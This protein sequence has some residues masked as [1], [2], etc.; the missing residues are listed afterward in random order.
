MIPVLLVD[1]DRGLCE[2]LRDG[3]ARR[4]YEAAVVHDPEKVLERV[5]HEDFDAIVCDVN[6]PGMNGIE[7]CRRIVA[8]RADVPVI[9]LTAFGS[10]DTAVAAIRA[11]A[12]DFISKPV[13]IDALALALQRAV[14][15]RRLAT[16]VRRLRQEMDRQALPDDVIGRSAAMRAVHDLI[17]R[18]AQTDASVLITGES[19]TGKEV[20]AR[21]IHAASPRAARPFVAI[22]CA[23]LPEALLESELF[24]HVRGAFTDA[25]ESRTGLLREADG[26]TVFLDEIGDMPLGLQPKL[27]RVLQER[28]VR[29]IGGGKEV[30]IDVRFVSAT[31]RD[32]RRPWRRARNLCFRINVVGTSRSRPCAPAAR[33]TSSRSCSASLGEFSAQLKKPCAASRRRRPKP[34]RVSLAGERPRA[35]EQHREGGDARPVRHDRDRRP[36][37]RRG[38]RAGRR[39]AGVA[40]ARRARLAQREMGRH[41]IPCSRASRATRPPPRITRIERKTLYRKLEQW[42][43]RSGDDELPRST[44]RSGARASEPELRLQRG[45]GVRGALRRRRRAARRVGPRV[46]G[47]SFRVIAPRV[48]REAAVDPLVE[49]TGA[50]GVGV[51]HVAAHRDLELP[52]DHEEAGLHL[53]AAADRPRAAAGGLPCGCSP[54]PGARTAPRG[55]DRVGAELRRRHA[56]PS[57]RTVVAPVAG[58]SDVAVSSRGAVARVRPGPEPG[59]TRRELRRLG[60][61][62]LPEAR[63][64]GHARHPRRAPRCRCTAAVDAVAVHGG[65][66]STRRPSNARPRRHRAGVAVVAEEDVGRREVRERAARPA[67]RGIARERRQ[68]LPDLQASSG[69]GLHGDLRVE[70]PGGGAG[71]LPLDEVR[72]PPPEGDA[73]GRRA[74]EHHA[75][76]VLARAIALDVLVAGLDGG[77]RRARRRR[78]PTR[79]P[80]PR[81]ARR[82]ATPLARWAVAAGGFASIVRRARTGQEE[83]GRR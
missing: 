67:A 6:M 16:E 25:R 18:V 9:V 83:G 47:W 82:R 57:R 59:T 66:V 7:L 80:R 65:G 15:H 23:A 8:A 26:G 70:Q 46:A 33:R 58:S 51:D 42:G 20:V 53:N 45:D 4:G 64:D 50:P 54:R 78:S 63:V 39:R 77:G 73:A 10:F 76:A 28:T 60:V 72:E 31:N 52:A 19:G 62:G 35:P 34:D 68:E 38:R 17:G 1:D 56:L 44:R 30:P 43:W 74:G 69:T 13:K 75:E 48:V 41:H 27:L 81:R 79:R 40:A 49:R 3:L 11:G 24:G 5:L 21:R 12:Y 32:L 36:P 71:Q 22:N 29:P 2:T 37:A 55:E 61:R 14:D